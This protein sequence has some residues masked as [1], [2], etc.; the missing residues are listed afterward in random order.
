MPRHKKLTKR[1]H[2]VI[3]ILCSATGRRLVLGSSNYYTILEQ[4]GAPVSGTR[5]VAP[6][7]VNAL[8]AAGLLASSS[9]GLQPNSD[10]WHAYGP[11][12]RP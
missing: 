4:S 5:G 11:A 7:V 3:T 12:R 2:E 1:Q 10:A 9:D 6:I 8:Q